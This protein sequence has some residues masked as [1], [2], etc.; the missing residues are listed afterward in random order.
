MWGGLGG[1][2]VVVVVVLRAGRWEACEE[3][4]GQG[5]DRLK[6][7]RRGAEEEVRE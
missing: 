7:D 6:W 1:V 3:E 2:A 5:S 4:G